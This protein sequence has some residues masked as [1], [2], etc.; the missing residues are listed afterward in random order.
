MRGSSA[1]EDAHGHRRRRAGPPVARFA[2]FGRITQDALRFCCAELDLTLDPAT[3]RRLCDAWLRLQPY[4]DMPGSVRRLKDAHFPLAILSNG[5]AQSLAQLIANSGMKWGFDHVFSVD[6]VQVFKPD[7]R[8]YLLAEQ[9]LGIAR[10]KL[11]FVS[12]NA[13]DASAAKLFGFQVCW[14]N[15]TGRPFEQLECDRPSGLSF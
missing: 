4:A 11:L 14:I 1:I 3:L 15:R 5:S 12:G 2:S 8:V 7:V 13:W 10:E 6:A 9:G